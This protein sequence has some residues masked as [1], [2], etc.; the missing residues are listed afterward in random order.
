MAVYM[1][2]ACD[3]WIDDDYNPMQEHPFA[4]QLPSKKG[5]MVCEDCYVELEADMKEALEEDYRD[6][7]Y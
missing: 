4:K 1:C 3:S 5:E 7:S 6:Q 2:S